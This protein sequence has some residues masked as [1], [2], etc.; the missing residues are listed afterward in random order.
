MARA[1]FE[2]P[3][4]PARTL[5]FPSSW[6]Q[7]L[8]RDR[9]LDPPCLGDPNPPQ[10]CSHPTLA[11]GLI[12]GAQGQVAEEVRAGYGARSS[13]LLPAAASPGD[14]SVSLWVS[15]GGRGGAM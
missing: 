15:P 4:C 10:F 1:L 8:Q 2:L 3:A 12:Q 11:A 9:R 14:L 5:S 7:D 13:I 6:W